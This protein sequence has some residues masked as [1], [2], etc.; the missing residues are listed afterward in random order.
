MT[1]AV[2]QE[3]D[4]LATR[5]RLPTAGAGGFLADILSLP[6]PYVVLTRF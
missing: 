4:V 5:E 6:P 3:E 2:E 1:L